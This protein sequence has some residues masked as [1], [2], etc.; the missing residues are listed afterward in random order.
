MGSRNNIASHSAAL[1]PFLPFQLDAPLI[2]GDEK[3]MG[4]DAVKRRVLLVD[5]TPSNS[6]MLKVL[7]MRKGLVC[8][9]ATN[10]AIA[11][12]MVRTNIS[13]SLLGGPLATGYSL[14]FMD[15]NMPIMDGLA[16]TRI[17]RTTLHFGSIIVGCSGNANDTEVEEF[18]EAGADFVMPKP[19][20][21]AELERLLE[22]AE[23][24]QFA[25]FPNTK[26]Q[27]TTSPRMS[28]SHAGPLRTEEGAHESGARA[29]P[30]RLKAVPRARG[31]SV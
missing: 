15:C 11:V 30:P 12:E 3:S 31:G 1:A 7:L 9:E 20:R 4:G 10:G 17:L 25:S 14:V 13:E 6:K 27:L 2:E 5:D 24:V 26:L 23:V 16:A 29:G 18:I 28:V 22:Y 8:D 21:I 19:L